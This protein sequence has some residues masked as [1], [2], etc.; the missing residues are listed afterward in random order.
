MAKNR[1]S[2]G[3]CLAVVTLL[4]SGMLVQAKE[5]KP[6]KKDTKPQEMEA[7]K[8]GY[9]QI[10]KDGYLLVGPQ[11]AKE[12]DSG[13]VTDACG[14][15]VKTHEEKKQELDMAL[16]SSLTKAKELY[17]L[18]PE[19]KTS[20]LAADK[21]RIHK[22]IEQ[23]KLDKTKTSEL[24]LYKA[25]ELTKDP[26]ILAKAKDLTNALANYDQSILDKAR[27]LSDI[28]AKYDPTSLAK[29]K[30]LSDT[31]S[32]VKVSADTLN[33]AKVLTDA[34]AKYNPTMLAKAK[35]LHD[36]LAKYDSAAL[37]KPLAD[38]VIS[39]QVMK[40]FYLRKAD[41][42][43]AALNAL[44][45]TDPSLKKLVISSNGDSEILLY[46]AR[47]LRRKARRVIAL[48]DLPRASV[49]MEMWGIEMSSDNPENLTKAMVRINQIIEESRQLLHDTYKR[50][51]GIFREEI[52]QQ[53][54]DLKFKETLTEKLEYYSAL[55][56]YRPLSLSDMLL[57]L[58][59]I[60]NPK[61][62]A[63]TIADKLQELSKEEQYTEFVKGLE[64]SK[65]YPFKNFLENRGMRLDNSTSALD[66]SNCVKPEK[67][68][69]GISDPLLVWHIRNCPQ[70]EKEVFFNQY[71]VLEFALN[72]RRTIQDSKGFDPY[73]LQMSADR[74]NS[75]LQLTLDAIN[76][77]IQELILEPTLK[78]IE[79]EVRKTR[80]VDFARVGKTH[81]AGLSGSTSEINS[82]TV[83]IS[84]VNPPL[85]LSDLIASTSELYDKTNKTLPSSP[86]TITGTLSLLGTLSQ[87]R[88][89]W[90]ELTAG[91]TLKI[92][93]HVLHNATS[94]ELQIDLTSGN[95]NLGTV[96]K[97]VRPLSR[98]SQNEVKT[99][100]YI[101]TFD[102]FALST[103][104]DQST[105]DGGRTYVPLVGT[106]WEGLFSGV[107]VFGDLFSW[108][109][110]SKSIY[111]Q[112]VVLTNTFLNPT[113]MQL[114]LLYPLNADPITPI[115]KSEEL[116][117]DQWKESL[118]NDL[119]K[120]CDS[121]KEFRNSFIKTHPFTQEP[122]KTVSITTD[123]VVPLGCPQ[124]PRD[125]EE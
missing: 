55:D 74:L 52:Q 111:H 71:A 23:L 49:Q 61:K 58:V 45:E 89:L 85:R 96:G 118:D 40:L 104:S 94:A 67:L 117:K 83:S 27:A 106:V 18:F 101:N 108:K 34:V 121:L 75:R 109:N 33:K 116:V 21:S 65:K 98:V 57:R 82:N 25:F 28:L 54:L 81:V 10:N 112:S 17:M 6:Q 32:K 62:G 123:K 39:A 42:V 43:A 87:N 102:L 113:V 56:P 88:T 2:L 100:V 22:L 48:L 119:K 114:G 95:P 125:S 115:L 47:C 86:G 72:Y 13:N 60:G 93:P 35:A 31:L 103:F 97:G 122:N 36:T 9:V 64:E 70:F 124:L 105:I 26:I 76:L 92:T 51:E 16:D 15:V 90:R 59:A 41:E 29:I 14:E 4:A 46:G 110:P 78:K 69:S 73:Y 99:N 11:P 53:D 24:S 68:S 91:T 20:K 84:D 79:V 120:R 7:K 3:V 38:Q 63:I 30:T 12:T 107:P 37:V 80:D 19:A 1:V 50:L 5:T 77:D 66:R 8:D 44:K